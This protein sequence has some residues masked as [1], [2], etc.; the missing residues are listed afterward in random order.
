MNKVQFISTKEV[1]QMASGD[2][3]SSM[4]HAYQRFGKMGD[5]YQTGLDAD[6]KANGIKEP[7]TMSGRT[8]TEGHH[9]YY[10][11]RNTGKRKMP[12][13]YEH[14]DWDD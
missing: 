5:E 1:G 8:V 11:A 3:G 10:A 6:V 2:H 9:R 7:I 4:E 14:P 12:V 13:T